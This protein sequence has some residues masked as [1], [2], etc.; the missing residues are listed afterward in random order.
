MSGSLELR[1][2]AFKRSGHAG[3][4]RG[5]EMRDGQRSH[6]IK[7]P[8]GPDNRSFVRLA[9]DEFVMEVGRASTDE[10][11]YERRYEGGE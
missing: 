8:T 10:Q 11:A 7:D 5:L 9:K 1:K 4:S 2:G 3:E 6:A